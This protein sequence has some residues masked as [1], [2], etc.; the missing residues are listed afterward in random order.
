MVFISKILFSLK[1]H[2]V[3]YIN[4]QANINSKTTITRK[5][6]AEYFRSYSINTWYP[7]KGHTYLNKPAA[8]SC[9]L[10]QIRMAFYW[11]PSVKQL[12]MQTPRKTLTDI[13]LLDLCLNLNT[14]SIT[15]EHLMQPKACCKLNLKQGS[16][17][18]LY[19]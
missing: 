10:A 17:K 6:W 4:E 7:L 11:S 1:F 9:R 18:G 16:G 3:T 19:P 8:E 2:L 5:N 14:L 12:T 13:V 15:L